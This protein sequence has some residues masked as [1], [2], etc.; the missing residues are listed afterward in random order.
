V[1][2][3]YGLTES[4]GPACMITGEE[5]IRRIGSAGKGFL[6]TE[7]RVVDQRGRDIDVGETGEIIVAADHV[8][9]GYWNNPEATAET[10]RDGWLHTG[11][12]ARVDEDGFIYIVDR[13]KDMI[14][15][16]GENIYP[17]EVEE[18]IM[19]H[20]AV[21]EA[22]VIG[23]ADD[24]WGEVPVAFVVSADETLTGAGILAFLDGKIARYK[25]PR[26]AIF[27]EAL[28]RTPSGKIM[29]HVLRD[30]GTG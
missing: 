6:H 4:C 11:D 22:G 14:I 23:R 25:M 3:V 1:Q 8:M 27:V 18:A 24:K 2:Q 28:P 9:I 5:A 29:K 10:I 19:S 16:G 12:A 26:E 15:S 20:P 7:V 30:I 21:I 17:A 13:I